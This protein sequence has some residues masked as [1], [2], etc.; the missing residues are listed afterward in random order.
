[1]LLAAVDLGSNSFRLEI[2]HASQTQIERRDYWKE[3]VRLVVGLGP[4]QR[5]TQE[6]IA[7][8][9]ACLA[10]MHE[11]LRGFAPT[12]VRAVGTQ[13]L[14]LARN[15]D[16]FLH[17][18]EYALGYPIEIISGREEA[19]LAFEGCMHT[20]PPSQERR[21]VIDIGGAST[22]IIVGRNF[23]PE[24]AESFQVGCINTRLRFFKDGQIDAAR[25]KKAH[26]AACAEFEP[27]AERYARAHWD[28]AY[29]AS[30][31][32]SAVSDILRTE[33]W[34]DGTLTSEGLLKLKQNLIQTGE[35]TRIHF[36]GMN[37]ERQD[38][39]AGGLA[40]LT[41]L[42][43][44]LGISALH[45]ARGALR[46]GVL[47]DLLNRRAHSDLR[48][49]TVERLQARFDVDRPQAQRVADLSKTLYQALYT[50]A[51]EAALQRLHWAA[52]LHEI[53]L[54]ISHQGHHKHGAY[55][56]AH[57]DLAGFSIG[58]QARLAELVLGQR[59][60]L[61]KVHA[62]LGD[63][64]RTAKI[65][66]LRLAILFT[67]ARRPIALPHWQLSLTPS[68]IDLSLAADWLAR[69]PL[70]AYSLEIETEH[71]A[72]VGIHM[73]VHPT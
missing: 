16:E 27:A 45:P 35:I 11:R 67:R 53:G 26:M 52:Q 48:D 17:E 57:A 72:K 29:G 55:L 12:C 23:E 15:I 51:D 5:L 49:V 42:F 2:G 46:I 19:R 1:M 21:L 65:L 4:D 63:P 24:H 7:T 34:S 39:I 36:A 33:G 6:A 59:G 73:R 10:R 71:W 54:T 28:Q 20:L 62:S 61:R 60:H 22:E 37:P 44:T 58:E 13:A 69:H 66:A 32:V 47:H 18:A 38:V 56:I 31:T 30:G 3:S 25:F 64:S 41:A 50:H 70:I 40:V 43:E 14:R 9:C 8:A 68:G